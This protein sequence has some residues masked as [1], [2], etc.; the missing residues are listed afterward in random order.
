[1]N[2]QNAKPV[3]AV[4]SKPVRIGANRQMQIAEK[5]ANMPAV[6]KSAARRFAKIAA[7]AAAVG[8]VVFLGVT[9]GPAL[10]ERITGA[11]KSSGM[12]PS[13]VKV[14]GCSLPVHT[15]LIRA[16][17][18]MTLADS[19]SFCRAGILAAAAAIPEIES[20]NVK[21]VGGAKDK[22][23]LINVTERRPVAI[24]HDGG[25]FLVDKK[26]V[27]FSPIPGRFYDLPLLS[28]GSV[29]PGDTVD[30]ELFNTIKKSARGL[31]KAFFRE[32][33][34]IDLRDGADVNLIFRSSD[35]EY[36]VAAKDI[37]K[38]LA[39]VKALKERLTNESDK[40]MRVDLRYRNLAFA[41][42]R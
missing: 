3:K 2:K 29:T 34:E 12:L 31:D 28:L 32:I 9:H 22:A 15:S 27:C 6:V 13:A 1:M 30:L 10:S 5:R 20:V 37:E 21:K 4:K 24:V 23:T 35:T 25:I 11:V 7:C 38:R 40:T 19:S 41:T 17:D 14:T 36:K 33:S 26:G 18:L 16:I 39:H 8:G 42:T